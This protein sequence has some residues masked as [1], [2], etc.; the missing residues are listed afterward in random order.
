MFVE[1]AYTC[2]SIRTIRKKQ[3][4]FSYCMGIVIVSEYIKQE[5][6]VKKF[7]CSKAWIR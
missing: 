3:K 1:T 7:T 6:P 2:N 4:Y 5:I